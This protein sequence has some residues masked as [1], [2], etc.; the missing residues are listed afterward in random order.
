MNAGYVGGI[1][2]WRLTVDF[3]TTTCLS[4]ICFVRCNNGFVWVQLCLCFSV[5]M[6]SATVVS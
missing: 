1:D 3:G 5:M 2:C 6:I 4:R